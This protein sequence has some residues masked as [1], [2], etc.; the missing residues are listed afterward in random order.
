MGSGRK[1]SLC[2]SSCTRMVVAALLAVTTLGCATSRVEDVSGN[3]FSMST[4]A[5]PICDTP[6]QKKAQLKGA[7]VKTLESGF[8]R[9]RVFAEDDTGEALVSEID[10]SDIVE[11]AGRDPTGLV[12][13]AVYVPNLKMRVRMYRE[14]EPGTAGAIS[15]R[16]VLGPDWKK[17]LGKEKSWTCTS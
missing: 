3:E 17:E 13:I 1:A 4:L 16:E 6:G 10:F 9:F 11:S 15:A 7:A 14:G 2:M 8:D 12:P 5:S